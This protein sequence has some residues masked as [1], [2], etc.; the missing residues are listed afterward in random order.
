MVLGVVDVPK[1]VPMKNAEIIPAA[2]IGI[3]RYLFRICL[4]NFFLIN[5]I[6]VFR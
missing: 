3:S 4:Y 2:K 1:L 5:Q 6:I